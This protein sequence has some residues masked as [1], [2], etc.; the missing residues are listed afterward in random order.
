MYMWCGYNITGLMFEI[1]IQL[2]YLH[3]LFPSKY[4]LPNPKPF[5][6]NFPLLKRCCRSPSD[7]FF[8]WFVAYPFIAFTDSN[9][10]PAA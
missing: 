7:S 6:L 9:Y 2:Y 3:V 10:V 8:I 4:S 5:H 1:F